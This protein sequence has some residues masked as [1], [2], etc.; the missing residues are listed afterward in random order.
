MYA[1]RSLVGDR[2]QDGHSSGPRRLGHHGYPRGPRLPA[3]VRLLAGLVLS[4]IVLAGCSGGGDE[5]DEEPTTSSPP[6]PAPATGQATAVAVTEAPTS[7]PA[8]GKAVVCFAVSGTG[9]VSHVAIHWDNATHA[10]EPNRS[11][12]SYDLGASYPNN[13][14]SADPAGYQLQPSGSRFCTAATMPSE[15]SIFVVA[16]A[17][18]SGG[19]PGDLSPEREIDVSPGQPHVRIQN[20]AYNPP[21]LTVAAGTTVT[22]QNADA[23]TH[24]LTGSGFDTGDIQGGQTDSFTAPAMPGNYPFSCAYH[25]TMT[26]TLTVTAA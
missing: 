4:A 22:V 19:A 21:T 17:I 10:T 2:L 14:T 15:G 12:N 5:G 9:R 23:T 26:G 16:H 3:M 6:T 20:F 25:S 1:P 13:R 18:D 7:A 8:G 11:F 24:T